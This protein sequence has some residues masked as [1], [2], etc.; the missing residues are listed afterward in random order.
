MACFEAR[1]GMD[2]AMELVFDCRAPILRATG[3]ERSIEL[4]EGRA[5]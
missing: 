3:F 4:P 1:T 2:C 5:S